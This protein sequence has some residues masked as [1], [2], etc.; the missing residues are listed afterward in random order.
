MR[1]RAEGAEAELEALHRQPARGGAATHESAEP[2]AAEVT[3]EVGALR[4]QLVA[5]RQVIAVQ[6]GELSRLG[7]CASAG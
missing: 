5:L 1:L 3:G 6:E 2:G 7:E 4:E